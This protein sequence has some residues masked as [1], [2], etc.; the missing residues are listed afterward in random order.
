MYWRA[1]NFRSEFLIG[2]LLILYPVEHSQAKSNEIFWNVKIELLFNL[3]STGG[4]EK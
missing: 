4:S 3:L 1:Q 2:S